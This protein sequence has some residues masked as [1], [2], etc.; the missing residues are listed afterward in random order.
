MSECF[1]Y[2]GNV[3]S[4]GYTVRIGH[5]AKGGKPQKTAKVRAQR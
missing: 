1:D 3:V 2:F 4:V 5:G